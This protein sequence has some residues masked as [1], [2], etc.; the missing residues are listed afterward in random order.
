MAMKV[1]AAYGILCFRSVFPFAAAVLADGPLIGLVASSLRLLEYRHGA[2]SRSAHSLGDHQ[3]DLFALP[4]SS[5]DVYVQFKNFQDVATFVEM[6]KTG[7]LRNRS[8][9]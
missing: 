9:I 1:R 4:T 6:F 3:K 8:Y 7:A 2:G 5:A